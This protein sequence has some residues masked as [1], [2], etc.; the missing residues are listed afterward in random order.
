MPFAPAGVIMPNDRLQFWVALDDV[1]VET[2][3]MQF[4]AGAHREGMREHY[5]I[6]VENFRVHAYA[7]ADHGDPR[8]PTDRGHHR[9]RRG[10]GERGDTRRDAGAHRP[11]HVDPPDRA[12]RASGP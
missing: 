12:G 10:R 7:E 3:C 8:W 5:G 6:E 9:T 4:V 2:G 1:T 11:L